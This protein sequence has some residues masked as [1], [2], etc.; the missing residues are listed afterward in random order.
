M[1]SFRSQR[2]L[3]AVL[4]D[5]DGTLTESEDIWTAALKWMAGEL[6]GQLSTAARDRMLGRSLG[7]V[8]EMLHAETA[9]SADTAATRRALLGKVEDIMRRGVPWRP[10]ARELLASVRQAGLQTALVTSSPRRL[11]D[12]TMT[13]LGHDAFDI[14]ICGDEVRRP[15]PDPEPYCTAMAM[16]GLNADQCVA[17]EDS[18]PGAIA[19]ERAGLPVLVVPSG[20]PIPAGPARTLATSLTGQTPY[21]LGLLVARHLACYTVTSVA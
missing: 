16:L 6:G 7:E 9:S 10:G 15:K 18:E 14:T 19:A 21:T 3:R 1:N 12:I 2:H 13:S 4:F 11:V 5:M 8:V 20:E 17:I